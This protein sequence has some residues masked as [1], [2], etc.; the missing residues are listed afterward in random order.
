MLK[1]PAEPQDSRRR[2]QL[3]PRRDRD[4]KQ[5][6]RV[7]PGDVPVGN[8]LAHV[9][10]VEGHST[11]RSPEVVGKS[12]RQVAPQPGPADNEHDS[13]N[14]P[15][16]RQRP[17]RLLPPV[18][19]CPQHD[20]RRKNDRLNFRQQREAE[21]ESGS[22]GNSI[23][24]SAFARP[25]QARGEHGQSPGQTGDRL[26]RGQMRV[27]EKSRHQRETRRGERSGDRSETT[28][29]HPANSEHRQ[30]EREG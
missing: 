5:N 11:G 30:S 20:Q 24:W 22:E 26:Q 15:P 23:G 4:Q 7:M 6:P 13:A 10:D 9:P 17:Q 27:P 2:E 12:A 21:Q 8:F 29:R 25:Q 1:L 19:E 18:T 14:E 28:S 16:D 3:E